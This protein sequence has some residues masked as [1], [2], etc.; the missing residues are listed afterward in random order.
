M[1]KL[2]PIL[3]CLVL[4]ACNLPLAEDTED[5]NI[6]AATIIAMTL[7]A[8]GAPTQENTP[9][10]TPT[11]AAA[12]EPKSTITPTYSVPMLSV[13]ENTNCRSGPGESYKILTT[14]RAGVSVEILGKHPTDNYW[15]VRLPELL[16]PCWLWGEYA[17][18]T[19]SYQA[20]P[21]MTPP[22][23]ST[24]QSAGQPSNLRYTYECAFN[25]VNSDVTVTLKWND[26]SGNETAYRIYRDGV[27]VAE[28]VANSTTYSETTT[29]DA[30]QT[31]T[32][33]VA[34]YNTAGESDRAAISF[35]CQ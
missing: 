19:G 16:E 35:S 29:A 30:A 12:G 5:L 14:L 13:T 7:T 31:L 11:Q 10:P 15:V 3:L 20:A 21:E 1:K 8:Q 28:L 18:A 34:A 23:T 32:Y 25:G 2:L 27:L 33:G 22:S 9:L 17:T 26:N 6:Q 4:T 24:P